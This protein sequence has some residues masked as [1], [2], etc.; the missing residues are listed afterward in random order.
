M[1]GYLQSVG[2]NARR[3]V[4]TPASIPNL[5]AWYRANTGVT[6]GGTP[7][8]TGTTP[9]VVTIAAT[10]GAQP[11]ASALRIEITTGGARGTALFKWS[12]NDGTTFEATGVATAATVVLTTANITVSFPVGTYATDNV[13]RST[14]SQWNDRTPNGWNLVQAAAGNQ[15]VRVPSDSALNGRSILQMDGSDDVLATSSNLVLTAHTMI[16]AGRLI[17]SSSDAGLCG[18]GTSGY[19]FTHHLAGTLYY[20][21]GPGQF[22]SFAQGQNDTCVIGGRWTGDT[23]ANG[24]QVWKNGVLQAQRTHSGAALTAS[25]F[26]VGRIS[27]TTNSKVGEV[28]LYNVALS[29]AD[30]LAVQRWLGREYGITVA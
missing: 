22:C 29:D 11:T 1:S 19:A 28:L 24:Q 7:L 3:I 13:Y 8:A 14:V 17:G 9:P 15:P 20:Y 2:L 12:V 30:V 6:L 10:D 23:T 5:Y 21:S 25:T 18:T 26:K 16:W 27:T 4:W